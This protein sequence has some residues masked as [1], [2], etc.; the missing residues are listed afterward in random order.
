MKEHDACVE[1]AVE[2][3]FHRVGREEVSLSGTETITVE[4]LSDL[5]V[6]LTSSPRCKCLSD[7]LTLAWLDNH[8][9]TGFADHVAEWHRPDRKSSFRL[10]SLRLQDVNP[11]L[12][13]EELAHAAHHGER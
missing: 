4:Y 9:F 6:R 10:M 5:P 11:Q 1:P 13:G 8:S 7:G 3:V 12:I 2:H